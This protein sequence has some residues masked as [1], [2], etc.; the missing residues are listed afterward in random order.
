M[1]R[2]HSGILKLTM[3]STLVL[4]FLCGNAHALN[5][6]QAKVLEAK[7]S[8]FAK[9]EKQKYGILLSVAGSQPKDKPKKLSAGH[10]DRIVVIVDGIP[11]NM[12]RWALEANIRSGFFKVVWAGARVKLPP[13][14]ELK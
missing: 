8:S 7:K 1:N 4:L 10:S 2:K 5:A 3:F 13:F 12:P 14:S 9:I 11:T 6:K